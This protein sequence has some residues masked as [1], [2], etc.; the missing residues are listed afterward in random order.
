MTTRRLRL[1]LLGAMA[2][3]AGLSAGPSQAEPK[4]EAFGKWSATVDEI[5]TGEDVRKTCAASTAFVDAQGGVGTLTLSISNGDALPPDAY[6]AV[7]L[8]LDNKDLPKDKSLAA[9]FADV[10]AKVAATF[11]ENG[12]AGPHRQWLM[13]NK[14]ATTLALLRAMRRAPALDVTFGKTPVASIAMDGFTKAYRSL[15][16]WCG[17]PTTDVAP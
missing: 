3:L 6:P 16:A 4:T 9:V 15:G 10:N 17:F 14:T 2:M 8:A 5:N 7:M 13:D 12:G 11:S 1:V